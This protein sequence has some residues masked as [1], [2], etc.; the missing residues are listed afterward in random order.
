M[1]LNYHLNITIVGPEK[2]K[3]QVAK[4]LPDL[5]LEPANTSDPIRSV[6]GAVSKTPQ[7]FT[8]SGTQCHY[9]NFNYQLVNYLNGHEDSKY[10]QTAPASSDIFLDQPTIDAIVNIITKIQNSDDRVKTAK[11]LFPNDD[12]NY[13][14]AF[15]QFNNDLKGALI[16][17]GQ[18]A[19]QIND[20]LAKTP[21]T[22][23]VVH[24]QI[25]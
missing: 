23:K 6:Y 19:Q 15:F 1:N 24:Y 7:L 2:E 8:V 4:L 10:E 13:G 18:Q 9:S 20:T 17:L 25:H 5:T 21:F 3:D 22:A 14:H 11:E 16:N 12:N